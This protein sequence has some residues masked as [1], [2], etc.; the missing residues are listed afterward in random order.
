MRNSSA[1]FSNPYNNLSDISNNINQDEEEQ[2]NTDDLFDC[3]IL[4]K[5]YFF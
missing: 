5:N 1:V 4:P 3:N 2:N